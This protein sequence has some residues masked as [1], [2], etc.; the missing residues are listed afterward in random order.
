M[1]H[2]RLLVIEGNVRAARERAVASGGTVASESYA[3]LLRGLS[4]KGT[5]VDICYPADPGA[6]LPDSGGLE[7]YDGVAITGS[8]LNV[9][10][11]GPAIDPQIELARALFRT[12]TPC[13]GSCWGLQLA[14]VA[15]GGSVRKN[16]EGREIGIARRIEILPPGHGHGLYMGKPRLFDAIAV[17]LD[18]VETLAPG[19]TVLATNGWSE[20]QAAE[21]DTPGSGNFWGVQYH[22]EYTFAEIAA[23]FRRYGDILVKQ[24]IF[25]DLAAQDAY[26]AD[27]DALHADAANK[28]LTWKY[29]LDQ[30][31]LD[32]GVR[33]REI[34]N[35]V[36]QAVL[37]A[38]SARGRE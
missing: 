3:E 33:T 21:I 22:P 17:H 37:P 10:D 34:R 29:A 31:V 36:E 38:R 30:T 27:L 26:V 16:P 15:A 24:G 19:T 2:L 28:P 1:S 14:T 13:F 18:E 23:V 7:G 32:A 11:G 6:N 35:W 5:V 20:V 9:Y 12:G 4:P 25:P 8:A